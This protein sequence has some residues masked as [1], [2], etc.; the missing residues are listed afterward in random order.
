VRALAVLLGVAFLIGWVA[1]ELSRRRYL[2]SL[3]RNYDGRCGLCNVLLSA[4]RVPWAGGVICPTC[5]DRL[6]RRNRVATAITRL[7]IAASVAMGP[8]AGWRLLRR[9]DSGWWI[10]VL[11]SW[12]AAAALWALL[13]VA[14]MGSAIGSV[15]PAGSTRHQP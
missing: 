1:V 9:N 4:A 10:A 13:R 5:G 12:I 2:T 6:R 8:L 7:M 11:A 14:A 15:V 3:G